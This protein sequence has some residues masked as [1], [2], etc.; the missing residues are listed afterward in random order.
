MAEKCVICLQQISFFFSNKKHHDYIIIYFSLSQ[1]PYAC[2]I[3]GCNKRYTD[4][5][6][7][8]K[9]IKNHTSPSQ[10]HKA[11]RKQ[12][13]MIFLLLNNP[14]DCLTIF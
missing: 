3:E 8:R 4:P 10:K 12:V 11:L 5:S 6:S 13:K 7:L 9:H 14:N 2:Q 1:K